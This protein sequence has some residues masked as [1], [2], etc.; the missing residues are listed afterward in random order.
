VCVTTV[1]LTI[2]TLAYPGLKPNDVVRSVACVTAVV[3][4][5]GQQAM[6]V[7]SLRA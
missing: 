1:T 6:A 7:G 4:D 3:G 2:G 5:A